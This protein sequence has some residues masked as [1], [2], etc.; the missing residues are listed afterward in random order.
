MW[1]DRAA[2]A[3]GN[4]AI[5]IGATHHTSPC[6]TCTC[7]KE[8]PICQSVKVSN[9]FE[10]ARQFTSKDVLQDTVCKV[11]CAF[12]FRALQEF[13]EPLADNQLGFS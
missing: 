7:T 9:C 3:V 13:S 8:G 12:V 6:T 2:C 4:T 10:L 11:Q 5:D 1:K